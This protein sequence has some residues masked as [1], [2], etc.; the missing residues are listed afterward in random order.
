MAD[1]TSELTSLSPKVIFTWN[2]LLRL[3]YS[4]CVAGSL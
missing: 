2:T 3:F 4:L 1:I